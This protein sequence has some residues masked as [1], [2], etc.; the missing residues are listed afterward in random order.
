MVW[1]SRIHTCD[2]EDE[3]EDEDDDNE[4]DGGAD[5]PVVVI[6]GVTYGIWGLGEGRGC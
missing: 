4:C 5:L 1:S 6:G 3:D 2:D